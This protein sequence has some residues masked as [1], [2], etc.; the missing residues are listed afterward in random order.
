MF[1][2]PPSRRLLPAVLLALAGCSAGNGSDPPA[3]DGTLLPATLPE[4][5]LVYVCPGYG[6]VRARIGSEAAAL[7]LDGEWR[8][9]PRT[10]SAS[11][12]R[13]AAADRLLWD[14]GPEALISLGSGEPE[15]CWRREPGSPWAEA[16][17][18]GIDFRALGQEPGWYL[19]IDAEDR[20][21]LVHA[22]GEKRASVPTPPPARDGETIR[23]R[24][25][26]EAAR[27]DVTI[28][29]RTCFD[30]MSGARF[31]HTVTVTVDG[32][33]LHGCGRYL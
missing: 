6:E 14:R 10:R 28:V 12:A 20:M 5:V 2:R 16:G 15:G 18:R 8:V 3:G 22:Y 30:S 32:R 17:A 31:P 25:D 19:E 1:G 4:E 26:T 29:H 24:A 9:L 33:E 23:Y 7:W 27:L 13:F 11:G 21:T